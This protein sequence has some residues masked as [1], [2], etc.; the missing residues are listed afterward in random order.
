MD[1]T[2]LDLNLL[3]IFHAIYQTQSVNDAAEQLH[4][5]QSACSHGLARLRDRLNDELFVRTNQKML[6]TEKALRLA[7]SV[8]PAMQMLNEGLS[9][10]VPFDPCNG[11]HKIVLS[12]TDFTTWT[13]LPWLTQYLAKHYPNVQLRIVNTEQKDPALLL[14]QGEIDFALGFEHKNEKENHIA[15]QVWLNDSYCT[16]ACA[17]NARLDGKR[18]TLDDFVSLSH[19][20]V[21][22]WN[23]RTAVVDDQLAKLNRKRRV[24]LHLPSVLCAPY[25]VANTPYLLTIPR[26]YVQNIEQELGLTTYQPPLPIPNYQI[27]IY[28]HKTRETNL[29]LIWFRQLLKEL[30]PKA[31]SLLS[32]KATVPVD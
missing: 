25:L 9:S 17:N 31:Q 11:E 6:P 27:K 15:H 32:S 7:Q 16:V 5:S 3:K 22:P 20:V 1:I 14:E 2:N 4:I 29:K 23:E 19:I 28:W 18:L 12:G 30:Q 13:L 10:S 26:I 8:L 24:A 21:T